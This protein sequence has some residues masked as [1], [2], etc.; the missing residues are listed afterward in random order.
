M[1][2]SSRTPLPKN[3]NGHNNTDTR[4]LIVHSDLI[5]KSNTSIPDKL[6]SSSKLHSL[7]QIPAKNLSVSAAKQ[8]FG[9]L[10]IDDPKEQIRQQD[11]YDWHEYEYERVEPRW[12]WDAA[13][14]YGA[15]CGA[16]DKDGEGGMEGERCYGKC[17]HSVDNFQDLNNCMAWGLFSSG[18]V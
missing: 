15:V 2:A 18:S 4:I 13:D 8:A 1:Y 7:P 12:F 14:G 17:V 3:D 9:K 16:W 10:R 5:F 11:N 6:F